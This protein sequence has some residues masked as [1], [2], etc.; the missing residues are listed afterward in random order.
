MEC[1]SIPIINFTSFKIMSN[2]LDEDYLIYDCISG[3]DLI[4]GDQTRMCNLNGKWRGHDIECT[5]EKV[6]FN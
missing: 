6:S 3:Y 5:S 4:K 2:F 1:E